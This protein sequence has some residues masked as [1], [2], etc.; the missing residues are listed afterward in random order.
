MR[1]CLA[2]KLK[3][4]MMSALQN[5]KKKMRQKLLKSQCCLKDQE[6]LPQNLQ[7]RLVSTKLTKKM[8]MQLLMIGEKT[9]NKLLTLKAKKKIN[10]QMTRNIS[11]RKRKGML[12]N[13]M[14]MI[15]LL[16]VKARRMIFYLV[17]VVAFSPAVK[18]Y[19]MMM[20]TKM[21][22]EDCLLTFPRVLQNQRNKLQRKNPHL[23]L[24]KKKK[25]KL[26]KKNKL[27]SLTQDQ[28]Q[29]VERYYQKER[30]LYLEYQK[31]HPKQKSPIH[32][33]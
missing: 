19:L 31:S 25:M 26:K 5:Q 6:I 3:K 30:Y 24:M 28:E 27:L 32:M 2:R 7:L 10:L 21:M 15:C 9:L 20:M 14:K 17:K 12:L 23:C 1:N 22:R 16:Q 8:L 33:W 18:V 4:T 11:M 29:K 13:T